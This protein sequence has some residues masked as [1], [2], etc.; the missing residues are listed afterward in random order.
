MS[1]SG[2][3]RTWPIAVHVS[4]YDPTRT[5]QTPLTSVLNVVAVSA[6]AMAA[7]F[8]TS[9]A[10]DKTGYRRVRAEAKSL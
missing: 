3:N 1:L 6:D 5:H 4:A 8:R 9:Q 2:V 7:A 10:P